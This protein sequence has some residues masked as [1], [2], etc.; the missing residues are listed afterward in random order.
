MANLGNNFYQKL[1]L[2]AQELGM[3]PEDVVAIMV[4]ES[5]I[6]PSAHNKN[7]GASGLIQ[8]MPKTLP[9]VGYKGTPDE[10]RE[11]SGEQ[12]I[13]Y[14]KNYIKNVMRILGG[15]FTSA[16]QYYVGVF[17]PAALKL[18]GVRAG[19]PNAVF[20]EKNPET[21]EKNGKLYSK[22][23]SD[24]G[25]NISA[26]SERAAYKANPAFHGSVPGAITYGDML[27]QVEK[28]KNSKLYKQALIQMKSSQN[29]KP[30]DDEDNMSYF[31]SLFDAVNDDDSKSYID[32]VINRLT[33]KERG[34]KPQ[35]PAITEQKIVVP[36]NL[37]PPQSMLPDSVENILDNALSLVKGAKKYNLL[38]E[39][40]ILIKIATNDIVSSIEFARVLCL[41]LDE[42]LQS[43]SHTLSNGNNVEIECKIH[44]PLYA[45]LAAVQEVSDNVSDMF[46]ISTKKIGSIA[47]GLYCIANK[48]SS[49]PN[50]EWKDADINYRKFLTKF[51]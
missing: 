23:Y 47:P 7:G 15:P 10:F 11:L 13:P 32:N 19:D 14:I 2:M 6:N 16:A 9:T 43:T 3:K 38:N 1:S 24:I 50:L 4:S 31:M 33:E 12:Q 40:T 44:G 26:S 28:N 18:P 41:A 8:F 39:N 21:V 22:K 46:S 35:L 51:I 34:V 45:C 48:S 25:I 42:E 37:Q 27:K 5:G 30:K 17:Y 20:I 49:L 36:Q 29:S